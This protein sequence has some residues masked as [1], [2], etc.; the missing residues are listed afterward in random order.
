MLFLK[1]TNQFGVVLLREKITFRWPPTAIIYD[2]TYATAADRVYTKK[3]A[4][5]SHLV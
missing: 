1:E 5:V 3:S 2:Y 4:V